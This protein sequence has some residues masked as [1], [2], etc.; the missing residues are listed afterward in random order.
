AAAP[1]A[2]GAAGATAIDQPGAAGAHAREGLV[3][4]VFVAPV[5]SSIRSR[6][7]QRCVLGF[8]AVV[9]NANGGRRSPQGCWRRDHREEDVR[10]RSGNRRPPAGQRR[11]RRRRWRGRGRRSPR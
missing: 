11:R 9:S 6:R 4:F 1:P 10:P 7:R 8:Q 2:G 5:V 3:F